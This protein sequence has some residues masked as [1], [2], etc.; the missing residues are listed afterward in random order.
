MHLGALIGYFAVQWLWIRNVRESVTM[1]RLRSMPFNSA[2][3]C[4]QSYANF[5]RYMEQHHIALDPLK[6]IKKN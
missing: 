5:K 3:M 6:R 1:R 2:E 4:R